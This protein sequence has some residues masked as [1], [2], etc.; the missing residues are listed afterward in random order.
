[1][2]QAKQCFACVKEAPKAWR[3]MRQQEGMLA[4]VGRL[5]GSKTANTRCLAQ[6]TGGC[7]QSSVL[8][9]CARQVLTNSACMLADDSTSVVQRT[10]PQSAEHEPCRAC[11]HQALI[12]SPASCVQWC[13]SRHHKLGLEGRVQ[14]KGLCTAVQYRKS[15]Q[16]VLQV[17]TGLT[18]H[19]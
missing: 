16:R 4:G 13:P 14:L 7:A 5:Y 9:D 8:R 10:H 19:R 3:V 18:Y 12:S 2:K 6:V 11:M 1:M 15:T 17:H